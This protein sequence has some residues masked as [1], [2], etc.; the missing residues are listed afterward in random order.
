M[1]C[2]CSNFCYEIKNMK[3]SLFSFLFFLL[4]ELLNCTLISNNNILSPQLHCTVWNAVCV[5]VCQQVAK[6]ADLDEE[7]SSPA[8]ENHYL[9]YF[10]PFI[11]FWAWIW[12]QW[13]CTWG[14]VLTVCCS[15]HW[16]FHQ[17]CWDVWSIV[18]LRSSAAFAC[19]ATVCV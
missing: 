10:P 9:I 1:W 7:D 3:V 19:L 13:K 15:F 14:S 6:E 8:K 12:K 4:K 5:C 16:M 11:S 2:F 18:Y 17:S